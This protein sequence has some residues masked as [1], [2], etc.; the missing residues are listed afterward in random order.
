[1][2]RIS[3][4]AQ[5]LCVLFVVSLTT[6]VFFTNCAEN[7]FKVSGDP[8][9][10]DPFLDMAWHI[11]NT[12][13]K[14]FSAD[15]GESGN[16]LNLLQTWL[17]GISGKGIK[18]LI[19]DDGVEDT[20][21][22]LK[23]NY[24]YTGVS[25]DYTKSSPYLASS[26]PPKATDDNHGTAVA[27][28][29]AAAAANGKGSK[30]V[31][32]EASLVSANFLSSAVTQTEPT[33]VDQAGGAFDIFSMSWGSAQNS[34]ITPVASFQSQ[35]RSG[36]LS[37]RSGK[38]AIYVK[39][40]GN[41]FMVYCKG[42]TSEYCT[43]NANFDSDNSTPYT[44]LTA[45]LN[46]SGY[47]A[48]Y[49]SPGSNVWIS[50]FG[51][52][53]GDD[54]PA[55]ITTDRMGCTKGFSTSTISGKLEFERGGLGNTNCNY[56]ATFNGTSAAAPVL[57]GSIALLL[58]A[59][60]NLSWRDVKYI[61]AKTAVPVHYT[62][63]GSIAH[64]K[65]SEPIPS[66]A[67]WEQVWVQNGAGFKFHNWYGFGRVNVDAA[68]AMARSYTSPFN[69]YVETNWVDD[70]SGLNLGI[71]DNSATGASDTMFVNTNIKIESVQLRVWVTHT[72]IA[73]LALE[74]TSPS[75]TK[76]IVIN[77]N[78]ALRNVANYQGEVFLTNAFYRENSQGNWTV[79]V[80]DG[81]ATHTGTLTR[82]SLNFTGSN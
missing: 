8:K 57:S 79:K 82:W 35:M 40:A 18:I 81:T 38:G 60:P 9:T 63:S 28:L 78:N 51:G 53:F 22:D 2:R 74:L 27:G 48:S 4:K 55:M 75:G 7:G 19:S 66:G 37:G 39:S 73:N 15:S 6:G 44:I 54:S 21:E 77:M 24:L 36:A 68:V 10:A 12:A 43:G 32:F 5:A 11:S 58:Q 70:R 69:A 14:V 20:H 3:K 76:S 26:S 42:S 1:M 62:T 41:D 34:L 72:N 31:A 47:A 56:T 80:I 25:K 59:N 46:A 64:P 30:G 50:S 16:D 45:A 67:V 65:P 13:Q 17:S 52:E 61:L 71:P 23:A 33:L 29:A 49:S